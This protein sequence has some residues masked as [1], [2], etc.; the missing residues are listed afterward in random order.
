MRFSR[1]MGRGILI[2]GL[3]GSGK[4]TIG[5][6]VAEKLQYKYMDIEKYYFIETDIPYTKERSREEC[7]NLM[8]DDIEK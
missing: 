3:N 1:V 7:I 2:F 5:R 4:S 8:I 6:K